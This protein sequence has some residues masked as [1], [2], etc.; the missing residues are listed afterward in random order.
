MEISEYLAKFNKILKREHPNEK[1]RT[2]ED[3]ISTFAI[4]PPFVDE[5]KKCLS[6]AEKFRTKGTYVIENN[7]S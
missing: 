1:K 3:Y 6:V 5:T 7:S 4:L 2:V